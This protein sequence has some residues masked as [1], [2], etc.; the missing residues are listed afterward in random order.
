ME[1]PSSSLLN[2]CPDNPCPRSGTT[3]ALASCRSPNPLVSPP[4]GRGAEQSRQKAKLASRSQAG[5]AGLCFWALPV[6][7]ALV[8]CG[9]CAVCLVFAMPRREQC[10]VRAL[11]CVCHAQ[12][13]DAVALRDY[14]LEQQLNTAREELSHALYQVGVSRV[15][16]T[17]AAST[18]R[19]APGGPRLSARCACT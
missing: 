11:P 3:T 15:A 2:P 7:S 19:H 9:S 10:F 5:L 17:A 1:D 18:G 13:W 4:Q 8:G 16:F 14:T 6:D 12:E